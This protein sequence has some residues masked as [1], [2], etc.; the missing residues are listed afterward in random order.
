MKIALN[1]STYLVFILYNSTAAI[2]VVVVVV[3]VVVIKP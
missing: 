2:V 1:Y 3:V